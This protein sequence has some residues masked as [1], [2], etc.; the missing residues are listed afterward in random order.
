VTVLGTWRSQ[1]APVMQAL[2]EDT[3]C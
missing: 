1:L 3:V 2:R